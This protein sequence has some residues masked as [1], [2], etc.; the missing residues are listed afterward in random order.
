M[1]NDRSDISNRQ[2]NKTN[3]RTNKTNP[4]QDKNEIEQTDATAK[5]SNPDENDGLIRKIDG[6]KD[7]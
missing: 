6:I 7:S 3:R 1:V 4:I 2:K 5:H